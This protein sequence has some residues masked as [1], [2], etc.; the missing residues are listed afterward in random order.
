MSLAAGEGTERKTKYDL[1]LENQEKAKAMTK[2]QLDD[3]DTS[4]QVA[5]DKGAQTPL[6]F[7]LLDVE[8][9]ENLSCLP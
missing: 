5:E 3:F 9:I 6:S 4:T 7:V 1:M 2:G 8:L